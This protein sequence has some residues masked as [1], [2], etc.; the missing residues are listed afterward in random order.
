MNRRA[1]GLVIAGIGLV[2]IIVGVLTMGGSAEPD[3]ETAATTTVAA[4]TTTT[5]TTSTSTTTTTAPTTT[6]T[7]TTTTVPPPSVEDFVAAYTA[8]TEQGD[9]DFL[10]DTLL[11]DLR[12]A[13]GAELCRAWVE[14]E[15]LALSDYQLTGA[16]TGPSAR[17]L[18]VGDTAIPVASYYE[19]PVSFTFQS[20][21]FDTVANWVIEDAT[22]YWIGECR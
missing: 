2:M 4:P 6:T 8:A 15:I 18:S 7:T 10:F 19:A 16:I 22:V 9:A 14:R 5:S 20:Q 13:F 3:P 17:T 21:S 11:P 12:D 1:T